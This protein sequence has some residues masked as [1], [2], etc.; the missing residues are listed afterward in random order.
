MNSLTKANVV[1]GRVGL[2]EGGGGAA[3]PGGIWPCIIGGGNLIIV[4]TVPGTIIDG[5]KPFGKITEM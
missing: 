2:D 1:A 5:T 4:G 3:I